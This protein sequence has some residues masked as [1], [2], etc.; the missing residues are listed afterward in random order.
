MCACTFHFEPSEFSTLIP[1][2]SDLSCIIEIFWEYVSERWNAEFVEHTYIGTIDGL[3][4]Q[5]GSE[6]VFTS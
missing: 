3:Q 1:D 2:D 5:Q 4:P 6:V